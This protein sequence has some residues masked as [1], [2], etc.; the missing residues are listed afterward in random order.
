MSASQGFMLEGEVMSK[1]G[2]ETVATDSAMMSGDQ[3][4][5]RQGAWPLPLPH[6]RHL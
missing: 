1:L 4:D 6:P 3:L 2:S 5:S